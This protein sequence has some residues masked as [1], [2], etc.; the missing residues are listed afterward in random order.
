MVYAGNVRPCVRLEI[1]GM[2]PAE[3]EEQAPGSGKAVRYKCAGKK[4]ESLSS[5]E[6]NCFPSEG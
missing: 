6:F 4:T 3:S 2:L 1:W 5:S